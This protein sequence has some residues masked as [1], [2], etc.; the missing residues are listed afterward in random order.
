MQGR[1]ELRLEETWQRCLVCQVRCLAEGQAR[2]L[3]PPLLRLADGRPVGDAE[4]P[5]VDEAR[6]AKPMERASDGEQHALEY[7]SSGVRVSKDESDVLEERH[8]KCSQD[9][10]EC[11]TIAQLSGH[12]HRRAGGLPNGAYTAPLKALVSQ[13][14]VLPQRVPVKGSSELTDASGYVCAEGDKSKEDDGVAQHRQDKK[15]YLRALVPVDEENR[16]RKHE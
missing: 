16:N 11:G 5:R 4:C 2:W 1:Y 15:E 14:S 10:F 8:L 13:W 6:V 3:I 12:D 9:V 7:V